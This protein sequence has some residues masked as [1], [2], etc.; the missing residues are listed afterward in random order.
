MIKFLFRL[1][2]EPCHCV[3]RQHVFKKCLVYGMAHYG[4]SKHCPRHKTL[5]RKW[6]WGYSI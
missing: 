1:Q 4:S 2:R 3:Y 6:A 5:D